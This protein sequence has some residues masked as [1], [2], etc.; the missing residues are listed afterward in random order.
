MTTRPTTTANPIQLR[1]PG[2]AAAPQG[3]IDPFM[4]YV[5]HHGFRRDLAD[6]AA[7]VPVTPVDDAGTWRALAQRWTMFAHALHHHHS[8]EDLELWP[9][10]L[11][12]CDSTE[13]LVLQ[14]M[15]AEHDQ[16]DPLLEECEAGFTRMAAGADDQARAGLAEAL[17]R[18]QTVL[19]D[20]L[21]HEENDAIAIVQRRISMADWQEFEEK[22]AKSLGLRET[23]RSG[24][25]MTK[26]LTGADRDEVFT[27]MPTILRLLLTLGGP[28]F[29]RLD[30]RAFYYNPR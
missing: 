24:P 29:R 25:L 21:A 12:R 13:Q 23:I 15:E 19:G 1:L 16:I 18:A 26:G 5:M 14:A 22:M 27:R 17:R 8:G 10:L 7:S 6:F 4:M 28:R 3:P 2:Q 9:L 20:H 11:E 30:G